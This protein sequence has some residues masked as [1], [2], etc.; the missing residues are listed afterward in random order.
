MSI[1]LDIT[2]RRRGRYNTAIGWVIISILQIMGIYILG[3]ID[4][5]VIVNYLIFFIMVEVLHEGCIFI[6]VYGILI[7]MYIIL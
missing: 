2:R 4:T 3:N 7:H 1:I 5:I 6:S